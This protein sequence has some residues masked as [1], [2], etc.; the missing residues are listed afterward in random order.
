[1]TD[2][3]VTRGGSGRNT[4]RGRSPSVRRGYAS[5]PTTPTR[6]SSPTPTLAGPRATTTMSSS[7]TSFGRDDTAQ[8]AAMP[9]PQSL[10]PKFP[11]ARQPSPHNKQ[12]RSPPPR[13]GSPLA[14][15][16]HQACC[17]AGNIEIKP[18]PKKAPPP[19]PPDDEELETSAAKP[20]PQTTNVVAQAIAAGRKAPPAP[21]QA[22]HTLTQQDH[23]PWNDRGDH[24]G[25]DPVIEVLTPAVAIAR[26]PSP[27]RP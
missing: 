19:I 1:M 8:P 20:P 27:A 23:D 6:T 5:R 4:G 12:P 2:T 24:A 15:I 21:P 13:A 14:R 22:T 3:R 9:P 11:P 17:G 26:T 18:M 7:S 10:G 25:P 16:I